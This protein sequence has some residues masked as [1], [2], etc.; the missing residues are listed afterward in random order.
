MPTH[1][2]WNHKVHPENCMRGMLLLLPMDALLQ[3]VRLYRT[4]TQF[5]KKELVFMSSHKL[6]SNVRTSIAMP[7]FVQETKYPLLQGFPL[8]FKSHIWQSNWKY[9]L[10]ALLMLAASFWLIKYGIN[11]KG[12]FGSRSWGVGTCFEENGH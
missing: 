10:H 7:F 9:C 1:G 2:K 4:W 8:S 3:T 11:T 5:Q 12:L 6:E